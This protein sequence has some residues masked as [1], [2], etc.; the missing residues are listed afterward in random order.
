MSGVLSH[1]DHCVFFTVVFII[2]L[3]HWNT[4]FA[5]LRLTSLPPVRTP[6]KVFEEYNIVTNNMSK[7][8]KNK[9]G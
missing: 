2:T 6:Y 3:H 5:L 4:V 8:K 9:N 1:Y 7:N